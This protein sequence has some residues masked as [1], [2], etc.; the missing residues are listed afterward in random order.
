MKNKPRTIFQV[1]S[2]GLLLYVAARPIVDKTYV[3]DFEQYCPFGGLSSFFSKLNL[4]AMA[5]TMNETQVT[6]GFALIL[7]VGF[8]GKL[9]CSY[10][11][12]IGTVTEWISKVG[13]KL[14][15]QREIPK[16][17]NR[18]LRSLKYILLFITVYFT[19][20]SGELFCKKYDPFFATVHMFGNGDIV[21]YYAI[22]AMVLT[23]AGSLF[24]RLF[25]CKYLCPLGAI[26]NIFLNAPSAGGVVL[27]YV[28]AYVYGFPV[29][30]FWLLSGLVLV[31]WITEI[32]SMK[33][34]LM[35][36]PR[37]TR[38][39]LTCTN[40]NHCDEQ[41][42]QG[43]KISTMATVEHIDCNLCTDCAY[44]CPLKNVLTIN[45]KEQN[46][47]LAP[48]SVLILIATTLITA[49]FI[50][51]T[52]ISLR[53]GA[54]TTKASVFSQ[55][56]MKSI[57]CYGSSMALAGTLENIEG[58]LGI[59][60]YVK[61]HTV[62]IY[63]DSSV[64]SPKKIK[65]S[66]FSSSKIVLREPKLDSNEQVGVFDI[67]ILRLF[68]AIDFKDLSALLGEK[69]GIL[70]F[71]TR[72]GEPVRTTVY[73]LP[74]KIS[75]AEIRV[76]LNRNY[77]LRNGKQV[78]LNFET[79]DQG[80][81]RSSISFTQYQSLIF[82]S[83]DDSFNNYEVYELSKLSVYSFPMSDAANPELRKY[84][85]LLASH[86]S[87][88]EGI[89]RFRTYFDGNVMGCIYFDAKKTNKAEIKIA[90]TKNILTYFISDSQ[91]EQIPN[92]F[93]IDFSAEKGK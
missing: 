86:L 52:T 28:A 70:G 85:D 61:S 16:K 38:N 40:C 11:C 1:G 44:E 21:L 14:N 91:T 17:M 50:E 83:Y 13:K 46:K 75:P 25:W 84:L 80:D 67:G 5:C 19:M 18:L 81:S 29:S 4:N 63:Y 10:I 26:S 62:N 78:E 47:Y 9:F 87:N 27:L 12:P 15:L 31:G 79:S 36:I 76:Q 82:N 66:L 6:L 54:D 53:W 24:F 71:E 39:Q 34:F 57:T 51:F 93:H 45:K 41:C 65:A 56:G 2:L 73:Y 88:D 69:E 37:I 32:F 43:I 72:F 92:P 42:P 77:I 23:L 55:T 58:I 22:S 89:V 64:I 3:A 68:D 8:I 20:T 90:L 33:S 49:S 48:V 30:I 7:G 60:T 74:S 35:P 59:D